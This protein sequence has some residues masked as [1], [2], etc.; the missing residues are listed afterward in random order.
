MVSFKDFLPSNYSNLIVYN[1]KHKQKISIRAELIISF[2][3]VSPSETLVSFYEGKQRRMILT[4]YTL[5]QIYNVFT[6]GD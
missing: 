4:P 3:S 1:K 6:E 2:L 5:E